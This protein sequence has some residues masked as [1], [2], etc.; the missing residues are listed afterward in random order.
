M[1]DSQPPPISPVDTAFAHDHL[2]ISTVVIVVLV[3]SG[4]LFVLPLR[5]K[6]SQKRIHRAAEFE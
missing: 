1:Q 2:D 4:Y 5:R 6:H 3:A